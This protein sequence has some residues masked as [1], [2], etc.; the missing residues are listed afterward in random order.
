MSC[1]AKYSDS[2]KAICD[3]NRFWQVRRSQEDFFITV[4]VI[5][6]GRYCPKKVSGQWCY[7]H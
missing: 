6:V 3:M 1:Q 2:T 7:N 4:T 5:I